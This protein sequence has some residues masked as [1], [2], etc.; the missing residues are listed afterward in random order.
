MLGPVIEGERVRLEPPRLE[1]APLYQR[2]MADREVTRYLVER[3]PPTPRQEE[4]FLEEA[5]RDVHRVIWAIALRS[6]DT[7]IGV[8]GLQHIDW[9]NRDAES[10]IMIGDKSRWGR[11]YASE[12]MRLRT[13]YAFRELNL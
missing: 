3:H 13:A 1:H 7:V 2:W 6:D 4:A 12:A 8:T 11:G 9:R 10:G 5:A